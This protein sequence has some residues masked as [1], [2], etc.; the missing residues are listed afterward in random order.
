MRFDK[1][2]YT[3]RLERVR[4]SRGIDSYAVRPVCVRFE[5]CT[6]LLP[7]ARVDVTRVG[8]CCTAQLCIT[9]LIGSSRSMT[10]VNDKM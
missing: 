7:P 1:I 10:K 8:W 4:E 5:T 9:Y 2:D 3:V 6:V